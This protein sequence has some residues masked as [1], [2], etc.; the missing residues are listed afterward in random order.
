MYESHE[1]KRL[2]CDRI[3]INAT[4]VLDRS[5]FD[6]SWQVDACI[7]MLAN[8]LVL[9]MVAEMPGVLQERIVVNCEWPRDWW[10]AFKDRWA[11]R[12]FLSRYPVQYEKFSIDRPVY[13][14]V[15]PH[16]RT[17]SKGT[18]L[19]WLLQKQEELK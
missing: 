18:H 11:P 2:S 9:T 14:A 6:F 15:C 8:R 13:A 16:V 7:D 1:L 17:E 5:E 3:R 10:Q 19:T 12:W 4:E